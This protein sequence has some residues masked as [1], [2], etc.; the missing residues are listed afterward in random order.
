[1]NGRIAGLV[2]GVLALSALVLWWSDTEPGP[3]REQTGVAQES[4]ATTARVRRSSA[5]LPRGRFDEVRGELE[6]RAR[7]GDASAAYRLGSVLG[8]CARYKPVPGG[9]FTEALA[10]AIAQFGGDIRVGGRRLD[11]PKVLDLVL[12]AKQEMDALCDG[13]G[14]TAAKAAPG[15]AFAWIAL[16][17]SQGHPRAMAEYGE[18]AF[19]E[20][21]DD[22]Q[23][24]E[25][26]AEVAERREQARA[27][28]QRALAM[29][30]D[31]ALLGLAAAHGSQPFL[32]QDMPAALA[33]FQAYRR[34]AEGRR[35]PEA[36][37]A[38][39]EEQL[40]KFASPEDVQE[41]R[42]RL[43]DILRRFGQS[44]VAR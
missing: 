13:V 26:A 35:N 43:P 40:L 33:Y 36:V 28:L 7:A 30:E 5:P 6:I 27:Y 39:M 2:A 31:R 10:R 41:A 4:V 11:D 29:G 22:Y 3:S 37:N 19:D 44:G 17:A 15:E 8:R 16:A 9:V 21:E 42:R 20:F 18:F 14:D 32:G 34:T 1:M 23:L 12:H 38:L 24:M 25:H